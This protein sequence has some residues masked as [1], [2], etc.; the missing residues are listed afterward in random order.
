MMRLIVKTN[1]KKLAHINN[2]EMNAW[3]AR[4]A[5]KHLGSTFSISEHDMNRYFDKGNVR[6]IYV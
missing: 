3:S 5:L 1:L 2:Y 4:S 6:F